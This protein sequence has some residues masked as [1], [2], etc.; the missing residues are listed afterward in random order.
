M[1]RE[2]QRAPMMSSVV[3][4]SRLRFSLFSPVSLSTTYALSQSRN[5][6]REHRSLLLLNYHFPPS[7]SLCIFHR[8][9]LPLSL[10]REREIF[11]LCH[12][13]RGRVE[14]YNVPRTRSILPPRWSTLP[15]Y[16]GYADGA[17]SGPRRQSRRER[18]RHLLP[19]LFYVLLASRCL[20]CI[21]SPLF[22]PHLVSLSPILRLLFLSSSS[23]SFSRSS[24]WLLLSPTLRSRQSPL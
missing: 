10:S 8:P 1:T 15:V 5:V 17:W 23:F 4:Y 3:E 24:S 11:R 20:P 21:S 18:T 14:R 22:P 6:E 13:A 2:K 12:R 16:T 9:S 7:L 19:S